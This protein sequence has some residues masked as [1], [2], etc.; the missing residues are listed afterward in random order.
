M[1]PPLI[2][3]E[4]VMLM[5]D[6]RADVRIKLGWGNEPEEFQFVVE[7]K[8]Q[9]TPQ[10][11]LTAIAQAKAL[12]AQGE[13]PMIMVPY[14]S[15]ERLN[16]LERAQVSGIDMCGNGIV[17]VPGH[18][19]VIRSGKPNGFRSSRPLN[20]PYRG[21]SAM[22][23]RMLL[24]CSKWDS[25][26]KLKTAVAV[27]GAGLSLPQVSKAVRALMDDLVVSKNAREIIR[28]DALK[29]LDNL[30]REWRRP[31]VRERVGLS[32]SPRVEAAT[33]LSSKPK[34]KWAVTGESSVT[35]YA[36]FGQ[37]RAKEIAV[38]SLP[39]ALE[40]F[41]DKAKRVANFADIYLFE[42]DEEGFF[43]ANE[44][45]GKDVR[46]ASKLQTWLELQAGDA[47]QQDA[48]RDLRQQILQEVLP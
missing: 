19:C 4:R 7:A 3:R 21:R 28:L 24:M 37:E 26:T 47:R 31:A 36:V 33:V 23:A 22:V 30:G 43:F 25:L 34:L 42:T 46:W 10:M 45:D 16:E 2:I 39:M 14:L 15:P 29:L 6:D 17:L 44:V 38:A 5:P 48:A 13:Q 11:I 35:R 1:L 32:F 20:N 8:A 41:G 9:N 18:V 27:A 12:V 40:L